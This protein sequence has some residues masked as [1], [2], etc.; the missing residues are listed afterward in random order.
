MIEQ[1]RRR[2]VEYLQREESYGTPVVVDLDVLL[3]HFRKPKLD[4]IWPRRLRLKTLH[5]PKS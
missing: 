5:L 4:F 2:V 1:L 3:A